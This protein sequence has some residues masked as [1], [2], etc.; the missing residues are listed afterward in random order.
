MLWI[1]IHCCD[2]FYVGTVYLVIVI[3]CL[4]SSSGLYNCLKSLLNAV[5]CRKFRYTY[6]HI[7]TQLCITFTFS[8]FRV[9]F[10]KSDL[11]F[12]CYTILSD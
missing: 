3:F 10:I 12:Q 6:T 11:Q 9:A 2:W 8:V 1:L 4:A 5:G 7:H